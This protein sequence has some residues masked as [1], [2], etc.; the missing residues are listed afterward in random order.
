MKHHGIEASHIGETRVK[1]SHRVY[2][3][4]NTGQKKKIVFSENKWPFSGAKEDIVVENGHET[5]CFVVTG[6]GTYEYQV[7]STASDDPEP[8]TNPKII[9]DSGA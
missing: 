9:I 3:K 1:S 2:W 7:L 8:P 4:N 5:Q 6:T